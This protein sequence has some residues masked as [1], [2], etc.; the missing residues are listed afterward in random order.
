MLWIEVLVKIRIIR[1][2][3][4][5]LYLLNGSEN[6]F[7]KYATK[8]GMLLTMK[9][10]VTTNT[11]IQNPIKFLTK[12][13]ESNLCDYSDAYVLVTGNIAAAGVK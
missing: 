5:R 7:S 12:P 3:C 2:K 13:T 11:K 1:H 8:N 10:R 4:K 6:E 9:R